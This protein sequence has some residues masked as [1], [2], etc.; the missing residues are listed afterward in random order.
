MTTFKDIFN[1]KEK[2]KSCIFHVL[3]LVNPSC[4]AVGSLPVTREVNKKPLL[5][6]IQKSLQDHRMAWLLP[7]LILKPS[8][9]FGEC[10]LHS[11]WA[12]KS[13]HSIA[14]SSAI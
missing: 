14:S 5:T 9:L 8:E 12:Q 2:E 6:H 7:K 4:I 11:D 1:Q 10:T 13:T 3:G